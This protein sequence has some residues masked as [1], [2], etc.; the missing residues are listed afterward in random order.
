MLEQVVSVS[1]AAYITCGPNMLCSSPTPVK[2]NVIRGFQASQTNVPTGTVDSLLRRV[3]PWIL[4]YF[5]AAD[6]WGSIRTKFF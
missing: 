5:K 6:M 4:F 1:I 2:N 3:Q